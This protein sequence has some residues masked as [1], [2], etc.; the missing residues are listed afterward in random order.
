MIKIQPPTLWC[1]CRIF[2]VGACDKYV[3]VIYLSS[4]CFCTANSHEIQTD[5]EVFAPLSHHTQCP[6]GLF[7]F[8]F[9]WFNQFLWFQSPCFVIPSTFSFQNLL[10][11]L[12]L[13]A[14]PMSDQILKTGCLFC[15]L[16]CC[17]FLSSFHIFGCDPTG[18]SDSLLLNAAAHQSTPGSGNS[19]SPLPG[20]SESRRGASQTSPVLYKLINT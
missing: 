13:F 20:M 1:L 14:A 9:S 5:G 12:L 16:L 11:L 2:I 18:P 8:F 4:Y 6:E 10:R 3:N 7:F 19:S 15:W 17:S